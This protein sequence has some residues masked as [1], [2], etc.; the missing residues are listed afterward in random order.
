M[1]STRTMDIDGVAEKNEDGFTMTLTHP[2]Y[3]F[4][5]TVT[6]PNEMLESDIEDIEDNEALD[7]FMDNLTPMFDTLLDRVIKTAIQKVANQ[8][9]N[10]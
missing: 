8:A 7:D 3:G 5:A 2:K 6:V 10:G 1:S 9:A 4:K